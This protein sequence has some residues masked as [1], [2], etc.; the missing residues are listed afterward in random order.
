MGQGD[1]SGRAVSYCLCS[2]EWV[3]GIHRGVL[4]LIVC[5]AGNGLRGYIGAC[6]ILL[7]VFFS[8]EWVKGIHR[9][10]LYLIVCIAWNGLRRYIGTSCMILLFV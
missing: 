5:V 7:F 4:Y 9:G 6:C 10:V 1:T 3:K 8:M 2:M